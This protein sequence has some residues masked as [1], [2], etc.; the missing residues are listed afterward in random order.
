MP[1]QSLQDIIRI[2]NE[3]HAKEQAERKKIAQWLKAKEKE[4]HAEY[5]GK[6]DALA[7]R[8]EEIKERTREE[9]EREAA[10]IIRHAETRVSSLSGLSDE[11]L[12]RSLQKYLISILA[13]K[14]P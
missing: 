10:E 14:I 4:I 2:E 5:G 7:A 6:R 12:V 11:L 8:R 13:G 1:I 9:A 3:L